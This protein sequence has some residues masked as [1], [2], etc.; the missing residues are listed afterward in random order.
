MNATPPRLVLFVVLAFVAGAAVAGIVG[1][2]ESGGE[3]FKMSYV[4]GEVRAVDQSG[5]SLCLVE[6]GRSKEVCAPPALIP[7]QQ[8]PQVG[9]RVYV[10]RATVI[11]EGEPDGIRHVVYLFPTL[12]PAPL[13]P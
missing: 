2:R 9:D 8:L 13:Q 10:A 5:D 4:R 3:R 12:P 6:S 11:R 7:G 1:N